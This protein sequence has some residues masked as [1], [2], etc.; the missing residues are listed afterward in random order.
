MQKKRLKDWN[1]LTIRHRRHR[2]RWG[3]RAARRWVWPASGSRAP[4]PPGWRPAARP[5][6]RPASATWRHS[7]RRESAARGHLRP[8]SNR[9]AASRHRRLITRRTPCRDHQLSLPD[10]NATL[11]PL[12]SLLFMLERLCGNHK[13]TP[14]MSRITPVNFTS[15]RLGSMCAL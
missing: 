4:P 3:G 8:P 6:Y 12:T 9:S 15:L 11:S 13:R 7:W 14:Q 1:K 2:S 10:G 5:A